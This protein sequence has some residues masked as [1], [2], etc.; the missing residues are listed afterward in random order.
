MVSLLASVILL[1]GSLRDVHAL[2]G[3]IEF[4]LIAP[5]EAQ[6][7]KN[8]LGY[9]DKRDA[10]VKRAEF[11]GIESPTESARVSVTRVE[12]DGCAPLCPTIVSYFMGRE[13]TFTVV[14]EESLIIYPEYSAGRCL[15]GEYC[16]PFELVGEGRALLITP[17]SSGPIIRLGEPRDTSS[18]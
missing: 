16:L 12:V 13:F 3:R 5:L 15:R 14:A 8:L 1:L 2:A 6:R 18:K 4:H 11:V 9:G 10:V 17:T 7:I